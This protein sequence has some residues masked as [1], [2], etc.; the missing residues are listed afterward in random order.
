PRRF[1][2]QGVEPLGGPLEAARAL[3]L[4]VAVRD[5]H[6][7]QGEAEQQ[8]RDVAVVGGGPPLAHVISPSDRADLQGRLYSSSRPPGPAVLI[9]PTSRAGCLYRADLQGRLSLPVHRAM[10][11]SGYTGPRRPGPD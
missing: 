2:P 6:G 3:H 11:R 8:R 5:Q 1:E 7:A 4:V 10:W 9:E